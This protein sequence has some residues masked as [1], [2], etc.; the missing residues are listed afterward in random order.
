M[1]WLEIIVVLGAIFFG[2]R[3]GGIG[4]GLCGGLGL[5]VLT[6]GFGLPIGSPPVDVILI[7]MTVVVAASALQAAGGMDYLVRLASKFMRKNPKYLNIIAPITT[8]VMTIMAGTGFIVFSMLPVIAEIAKDSGIRPSRTLAGSVVASQIAIS[9]SPIS[10]AMAAM[11]T[12]MEGNGITF[13]VVM[14]V[15]LPA[16]F[17]AAMV[18]AFIASR[19][20]CELEND[21]VYLDRLQKGL[22]HKYEEKKGESTT[23]EKF[24]VVLFII[25]TIAIV[26]LAAFPQLRPGFDIG[27]PMGTRDIIIICMLSAA[28]LMVVFCKTSPD[29]IVLA[30]T[31]RSGM[32]SLAVILGIV[33]LGTTFVDAHMDQIKAIAGDVLSAYPILLALV[34]FL[35]CALLYSQGAT[36]PLIIPLAIALDVPTW[37]ILASF[38]AVTGVFVL[39]T[40]PTSLAAIEF[41]STGST[42]VGKYI[43]NHPF[44]LPGLGGIIAGVAFG[45]IIAPMIV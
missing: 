28:C 27:K 40:Y 30:P 25:A 43:L 8:W 15:C 29:S 26:I 33:T 2:I 23:R 13:I 32:S 45:F 5:A 16:S 11:L 20:G 10:A 41:D 1:V 22:V 34:L 44:M 17:V 21:E 14:S 7:I 37:A 4:I 9:G 12:I 38:V 36:T 18:A 6:I 39:P 35:T 19:Q 31:F 3:M 42:R 24:S